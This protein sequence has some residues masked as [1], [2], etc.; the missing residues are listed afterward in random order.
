G[1]IPDSYGT[2]LCCALA[3]RPKWHSIHRRECVDCTAMHEALSN[4]VLPQLHLWFL[5]AAPM[6]N[7]NDSEAAAA[8]RKPV[9]YGI[10]ACRHRVDTESNGVAVGA[11]PH[12]TASPDSPPTLTFPGPAPTSASAVAVRSAR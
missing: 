3:V 10:C 11:Q 1:T 8:I 4:G 5:P 7:P 9:G 2:A 6:D 12:M